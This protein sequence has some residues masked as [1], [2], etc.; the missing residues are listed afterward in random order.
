[1]QQNKKFLRVLC[2]LLAAALAAWCTV[3]LCRWVGYDLQERL[4]NTPSYEIINDDYSQIIDIPAKGLTQAMPLKAGQPFY[5]VRF[6]FSTHGQLYKSGMTMVEAYNEAGEQILFAAGNFLNIWD[7]TFTEFTCN[8]AYIP[9]HDETL[10]IRLYNESA[11]DGPL[12]VWASEGE[13]SGMPLSV[14]DGDTLNATMAMQRVSDFTGSW[15]AALAA[16]LQKPLAAA[17]FIA[18]LLAMLHAP[19]YLFVPAVGLALGVTFT[20]VTPALV[21]PDEYTHLAAAYELA[22]TWSGQTAADED[23]NL[24]LRECDAAHFGT[25]TGDIGVLAYKNEAIAE[26]SEPGS[27]DVLTTHSEVKAGQGSGSYLAQALGIRLARA[28]G[29]NFYTMLLYG[30]LANLILY[31]L[32]AALAVWL[33][34]TSL[35]GLFA[36]VA[37]LPMPLQL[38]ASLS[39][40]AAVLGLVFSFTALCLRLR[41]EKA[42]WWQKILLIVLGG[43]TA[44]GKAIYLPV[45]LLCL[46]IPAENLTY[47]GNPTVKFLGEELPSGCCIHAATLVLAFCFWLAA[48]LNA[49]AYA[50]RDMNTTVLV[51]AAAAAAVLLVL[52]LAAYL[53]LHK[54]PKVFFWC[55]V[56]FAAVLVVG[57]AG[58]VY[59]VSHMGGGL[60]PD[61][62]T[63]TYPNGDSIWTFSFGYI[64]RNIPATVKLLLRTLPEQG[65]L[66][67]QGLLGT[68]LGE[69]I[70]YRIDVSWLLG[71]GL[72]LAVLA[73]ALPRQD[74]P[75]LLGRRSKAGMA[76]ICLCVVLAVLAAA[77]NWTPINYQTIF[78]LQGRYL[79]P[80]LPLALL[81]VKSSKKLALCRDASRAA[82]LCTS[83]LT[84]LTLLQGFG[85]YA[86]WQPVS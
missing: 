8:E 48:N 20:Y 13:V 67:L 51:T 52:A 69:P 58:G 84:M 57:A 34:S 78:G 37:L 3:L 24:L 75:A 42:V 9:D 17:V 45:I 41:S 60:D 62:L 83:T 29:K 50:A 79:L 47:D 71:V 35:R 44:P 59:A 70:V 85:L 80:I 15:P 64:C 21:A 36:C 56:A 54:R 22:S 10:T 82:A 18:V 53:K 26:T 38:A 16:R 49:V 23:G 63:M 33:A 74:E 46:L 40:D 2:S 32:L 72:L 68:T 86:A 77:L 61:Q 73:A 65:A 31:L 39:P 30:R 12:G 81:L 5:G 1:M 6:K 19:L 28:Q 7:D 76:G 14:T 43:L 4:G 27:P 55:K 11:W 25:K 66:W